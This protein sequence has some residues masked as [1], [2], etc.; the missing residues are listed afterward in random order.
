MATRKIIKFGKSSYVISL[1]NNWV[2]DNKLKKGQELSIEE[3]PGSLNITY[4][5][6][7][8]SEQNIKKIN[9]DALNRNITR[10]IYNAYINNYDLVEIYGKNVSNNLTQ[11]TEVTHSLVAFEVI[12]QSAKKIVI[13]DFLNTD[14]IS[15]QSIIKRMDM[16]IRTMNGEMISC[17]D[18]CDSESFKTMDRD[19]NRLNHVGIKILNKVLTKPNMSSQLNIQLSD[20]LFYEQILDSLEKVGDQNKR[21]QR[22]LKNANKKFDK[23]MVLLYKEISEEYLNAIKSLY[24]L[25]YAQ[26][27]QVLN[28]RALILKKCDDLT[29]KILTSSKDVNNI[30]Y[31][32]KLLEHF[33]RLEN[34]LAYI[35]KTILMRDVNEKNPFEK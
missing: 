13:K 12:E 33:M 9:F 20:V 16:I 25:D 27:D 15:I 2:K 28:N 22:I 7:K 34:Y 17:F 1:P 29:K 11:I 10:E 24:S 14:D 5:R 23:N 3:Y 21:I 18:S 35:A 8:F 32:T 4:S 6:Q 26:A 31:N 19:I 30:F